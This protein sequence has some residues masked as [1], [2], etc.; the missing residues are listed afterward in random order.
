MMIRTIKI[1]LPVSPEVFLPTINAYTEAF[2]YVCS[3]GY[4]QKDFNN[5]SLHKKTYKITSTYLPSQ[6][7]ISSRMKAYATL[8][9]LKYLIKDNKIECPS[10]KRMSILYDIRSFSTAFDKGIV[11][12]LTLK[13]RI[14]IPIKVPEYFKKYLTWRR[15]SATLFIRKNKVFLN[16][17]FEKENPIVEQSNITTGIDRGI[18]NIAVCSNNKFYSGKNTK[19][20]CKK[21]QTLRSALQSCGS[22]SAKRHLR[23]LSKKENYFKTDT[24]HRISKEIIGQLPG[25]SIIVLEDLSEVR[26]KNRGKKLNKAIGS[27]AYYQLEQFLTYKGEEKG[28]KIEFINPAFTSQKCSKCGHTEKQNRKGSNFKCC[29]CGFQLNADLN[30][31]RNIKQNHLITISNQIRV[32]VNNP[33]V[34]SQYFAGSG[35]S[36]RL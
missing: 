19:K 22:K 21:C 8:K 15:K 28:I 24:N 3:I 27:W 13:G 4:S 32:S 29:K 34:S 26:N 10:S 30:A 35:T 6:L 11:N 12:L 17:V 9:P 36:P 23:K 5:I 14:K 2:N 7:A 16:I 20:V 25:G 18:N 33:I 1:K 31:S